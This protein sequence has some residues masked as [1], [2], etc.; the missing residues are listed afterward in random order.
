V[1]TTRFRI[2]TP[3]VIHET[4]DGEVIV[5]NLDTGVYYS[6]SGVAAQIWAAVEAGESPL[7]IADG[8]HAR[9]DADRADVEAAV[10]RFVGELEREQLV[11]GDGDAGVSKTSSVNGT[12]RPAF[13][14]PVLQKYTDMQ[15]LLLLDPI[16]EVG[17]AGWPV[18]AAAD[19]PTAG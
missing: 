2:E 6:L 13:V 15:E 17:E 8:L 4:L 1:R 12:P 11:A 7:Q 10:V 5:V 3:P 9:Y 18:S 14:E 19:A 16:H